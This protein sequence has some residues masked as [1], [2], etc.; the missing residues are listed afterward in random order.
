MVKNMEIST[1]LV[2]YF[3]QY[4]TI[5]HFPCSTAGVREFPLFAIQL[6]LCEYIYGGTNNYWLFRSCWQIQNANKRNSWGFCWNNTDEGKVV[7]YFGFWTSTFEIFLQVRFFK[8]NCDQ[9]FAK[10]KME[11]N[12]L[13]EI[14]M[15]DVW[16]M[17]QIK[18]LE[19]SY[20]L[21]FFIKIK[22]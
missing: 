15:L 6:K 7:S 14:L 20:W 16:A 1:W 13:S 21:P 8:W 4:S 12:V 2:V 11:W 17:F 5:V 10:K 9:H 19:I 3:T 22:P 18:L